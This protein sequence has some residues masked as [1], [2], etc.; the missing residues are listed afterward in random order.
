MSPQHSPFLKSH[1]NHPYRLLFNLALVTAVL[2]LL[3]ACNLTSRIGPVAE[4][5]GAEPPT[6][7]TGVDTPAETALPTPT[8]PPLGDLSFQE[9]AAVS[10]PANDEWMETESGVSA[11]LPPDTLPTDAQAQINEYDVDPGWRAALEE[12]YSIDSPFVSVTT[13]GLNDGVGKAILRLPAP[14]PNSQ[15]V[16]VIDDVYLA[17]LNVSPQDGYLETA[18]SPATTDTANPEQVGSLV[19]GGSLYFVVLTPKTASA[20]PVR[21]KLTK[22]AEQ[23]G[24]S[25]APPLTGRTVSVFDCR[26]NEA[27]TVQVQY[28]TDTGLSA[29]QGDQLANAMAA[30]IGKYGELGFTAARLTARAPMRVVVKLGLTDPQYRSLNGVI[31]LPPDIAKNMSGG[32][33]HDVLHEM[34]HWIEDEEYNMSWAYWSGGK[35]WWL[36]TTA[37]NMVMLQDPAYIPIN[38]STYGAISTGDNRLALQQSPY[39]WPSDFY[40]HAQLVKLNMCSDAAVCPLTEKGFVD[41]INQGTY[42]FDSADAQAKLSANMTAY[43]RYLV[44]AAPDRAN[45]AMPLSGPVVDGSQ[46]G[47]SIDIYQSQD[48]DYTLRFNG[49]APQMQKGSDELG[50][51]VEIAAIINKDAVYPLVISSGINGRNPGR[52]SAL[53]IQAGVPF[54]YRLGNEEP[55]FYDGQSELLLQPINSV[56]GYPSVRIAAVNNESGDKLFR[57][58]LT[59]PDLQG[60]WFFTLPKQISSSIVCD[61]APTE[62]AS[63][64]IDPQIIPMLGSLGSVLGDFRPD[65]TGAGLTWEINESRLPANFYESGISYRGAVLLGPE[66]IKVQTA[67]N[68]DAV[69]QSRL[70]EK[71]LPLM[72]VAAIGFVPGAWALK[73]RRHPYLGFLTLAAAMTLL[74]G[75][76]GLNIWGHSNADM[77]FT[78]MEYVGGE[79]VPEINSADAPTVEPLWILRG[80][81]VFDGEFSSEITSEA[82]TST[83]SCT[84]SATY[85]VIAYVYKDVVVN[86]KD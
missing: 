14:N 63:A 65:E 13:T 4:E 37:E 8:P 71:G 77:T 17:I 27:G 9:Q 33:N 78:Q 34:A 16:A 62:G 47:E 66:N 15:L 24:R 50:E 72:M 67:I 30:A 38:L 19:P 35:T 1:K 2:L 28:L 48:S 58:R 18:V 68:W 31:Y 46:Y 5:P 85:E 54:W 80:T 43:A 3:L 25:C 22:P 40:V 29:A 56:M 84:G 39:Q 20:A 69:G 74:T 7:T 79:G 11:S 82:E 61:N 42:P 45:A 60:V 59:Q 32:A 73:K 10:L 12:T 49:Y 6:T 64:T 26:Q 83:A 70:P 57:A 51:T 75:C 52:P 86:W 76:L 41:A 55:K 23:N 21:D 81:A 44:G 53:R 36:E